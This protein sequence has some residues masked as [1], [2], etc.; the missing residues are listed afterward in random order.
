[1]RITAINPQMNTSRM[2]QNASASRS[3]NVNFGTKLEDFKDF[4][5]PFIGKEIPSDHPLIA[6]LG[7]LVKDGIDRILKFSWGEIQNTSFRDSFYAP[8]IRECYKNECGIQP[9]LSLTP[10]LTD[11]EQR[12]YSK[13]L[14]DWH[15][16]PHIDSN[17]KIQ[18]HEVGSFPEWRGYFPLG[19]I[20]YDCGVRDRGGL[21]ADTVKRISQMKREC[22]LKVADSLVEVLKPEKLDASTKESLRWLK[23]DY[24]KPLKERRQANRDKIAAEAKQR[25][26]KIADELG[27][28]ANIAGKA[29]LAELGIG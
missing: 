26:Q 25:A 8:V 11:R 9:S 15:K 10:P 24:C 19:K 22:A 14:E 23:Y 16:E 13:L 4:L 1:M 5:E 12:R 28:K 7:E 2:N 17:G 27:E 3:T 29:K 20:H 6:R 18:F 21:I